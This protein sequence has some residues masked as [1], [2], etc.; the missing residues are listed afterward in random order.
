MN[1][2][3][4]CS[5]KPSVLDHWAEWYPSLYMQLWQ[6]LECAMMNGLPRDGQAP[7]D[8]CLHMEGTQQSSTHKLL[9]SVA[10][11]FS[12]STECQLQR[13]ASQLTPY[14]LLIVYN[15]KHTLRTHT[16]RL[17]GAAIVPVVPCSPLCPECGRGGTFTYG[18]HERTFSTY[19]C[20]WEC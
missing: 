13:C 20:A 17:A 10:L 18:F 8:T 15:Y 5:Y 19:S 7:L 9:H 2:L 16:P 1:P 12:C 6:V 14:T 11:Y 4:V 3:W